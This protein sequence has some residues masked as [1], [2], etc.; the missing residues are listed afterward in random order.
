MRPLS[1]D[2]WFF[3][4]QLNAANYEYVKWR[5]THTTGSSPLFAA[6]SEV[7]HRRRWPPRVVE[8][9]VLPALACVVDP[10]AGE[11]D[12][13]VA[14]ALL[15]LGKLAPSDEYVLTLLAALDPGA[16]RPAPVRK[17]AAL[18]LG[19]L[20]RANQ[21]DHFGAQ[22]LDRSRRALFAC[23]EEEEA[24]PVLRVSAV[25]AL[26]L[27]ADQ[28]TEEGVEGKRRY[29]ERLLAQVRAHAW[30]PHAG[31]A[32]MLAIA[33]H[34]AEAVLPHLRE[35]LH[36]WVSTGRVGEEWIPDLVRAGAAFVLGRLGDTAD[37]D[38]LVRALDRKRLGHNVRRSVA[39]AL[40]LLAR[41]VGAED[42]ERIEGSLLRALDR[43]RDPA[44]CNLAVVALAHVLVAELKSEPPSGLGATQADETLLRFAEKGPTLR[45]G[46]ALLALG[47]VARE[48][49]DDTETDESSAWRDQAL[50][51]LRSTVDPGRGSQRH[52]TAAAFALGMARDS[53]AREILFSVFE[54]EGLPVDFRA[55]AVR[56]CGMIG[57]LLPS[58]AVRGLRAAVGRGNPLPI[59]RAALRAHALL[60]HPRLRVVERDAVDHVLA[61]L[62]AAETERDREDAILLL[63]HDA[64]RRALL[65]LVRVL[66]DRRHG[67]GTRALA[68]AA[69]GCVADAEWFATLDRLRVDVSFRSVGLETWRVFRLH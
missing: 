16:A 13:I 51:L 54:D 38:V 47:M 67:E 12:H 44:T 62:E 25:L 68:A 43:V 31:C 19:L 32:P 66:L 50:D 20:H 52:R 22:V 9:F 35:T 48:I 65:P 8:R 5:M 29:V 41:R 61:D 53:R 37:V 28:P 40:G 46:F 27:L 63:A 7:L 69:L 3:W 33:R 14:S 30:D 42:R 11:A 2:D 60:G 10:T 45:R 36:A 23:L 34:P 4:W 56:A 59:R 55:A 6:D 24:T 21:E 64:D 49:L 1:T 39:V 18:G 58:D 26:G 57:Y 15:A 17:A